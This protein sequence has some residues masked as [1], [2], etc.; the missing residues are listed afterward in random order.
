[1]PTLQQPKPTTAT[2]PANSTQCGR[3]G[4]VLKRY[5]YMRH[6]IGCD[7]IRYGL[8][9]AGVSITTVPDAHVY[10]GSVDQAQVRDSS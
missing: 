9:R 8:D 6:V 1:M 4:A 10:V 3:C 7:R 5:E 2:P